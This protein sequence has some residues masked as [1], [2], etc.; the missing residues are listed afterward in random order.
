MSADGY[1]TYFEYIGSDPLEETLRFTT[2]GTRLSSVVRWL[3]AQLMY[4]VL[5]DR[6]LPSLLLGTR[7]KSVQELQ[8]LQNTR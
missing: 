1:S 7:A 3:A 8:R 2:L 6:C 4:Y 5:G